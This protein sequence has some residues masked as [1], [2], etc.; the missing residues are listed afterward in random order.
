MS[1]EAYYSSSS[2]QRIPDIRN[3]HSSYQLKRQRGRVLLPPISNQRILL[4]NGICPQTDPVTS[5]GSRRSKGKD[6]QQLYE[7][8]KSLTT[9]GPGEEQDDATVV[10]RHPPSRRISPC[11]ASTNHHVLKVLEN[12]SKRT[13]PPN[14]EV[15]NQKTTRKTNI[16]ERLLTRPR[17][18]ERRIG[19]CQGS[20][21]EK[22]TK[23]R[24]MASV[25][26]K[27]FGVSTMSDRKLVAYL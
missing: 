12:S 21:C 4:S 23:D 11:F 8:Q 27:R 15:R 22:T 26:M 9:M 3:G 19:I 24:N 1:E 20:E 16:E 13:I 5:K 17:I 7:V 25:L 18:G 2:I 6:K 10:P 14:S